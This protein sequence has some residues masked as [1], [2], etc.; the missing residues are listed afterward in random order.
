MLIWFW[1][2]GVAFMKIK[3]NALYEYAQKYSEKM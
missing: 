2:G 3:L 1:L